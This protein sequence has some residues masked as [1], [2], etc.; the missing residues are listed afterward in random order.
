MITRV[1]R[2]SLFALLIPMSSFADTY[3][4]D[5]KHT[6]VLWHVSHLGFSNPSG[7]WMAEG[8]LQYDKNA[9]EKSQANI[10]INVGDID[11]GLK[12][13]NEHLLGKQFFEVAT[14][15][16][17][18]FVSD[19]VTVNNNEIIA[20]QGQLTLHGVTKPI[21]INVK[22]NKIGINPI[23]EKETLG[24]SGETTLKRSDFNMTTFL[25]NIGDEVK[26][27]IE[28]EAYK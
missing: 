22:Q 27:N 17:A 3:T 23:T 25:P 6:S 11:T 20:V 15:P 4:I 21:T 10:S 2:L 14:Y 16:K 26:L 5:S 7:K 28:V 13:L 18:T 9:P 19:K 8:S 24:F 1:S 12:D